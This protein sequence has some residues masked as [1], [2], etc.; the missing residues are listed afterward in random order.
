MEHVAEFLN[1]IGLGRYIDAFVNN[2]YDSLDILFVMDDTDFEIFGPYVGMLP[3]HLHHLKKTV[4]SLKRNSERVVQRMVS[5][6]RQNAV[7]IVDLNSGPTGNNAVANENVGPVDDPAVVI[8]AAAAAPAVVAPTKR[9]GPENIRNICRTSKE[10]RL[11]SLRHSTQQQSSAMR[12]N[13]SGGRRIIFRCRS[14]NR[15]SRHAV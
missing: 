8:A 3:G 12:D 11:E 2:G 6:M 13:K 9:K 10:V 14:A 1:R 4:F 5:N 15:Q 7:P